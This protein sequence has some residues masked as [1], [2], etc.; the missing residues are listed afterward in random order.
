[1][2]M[3]HHYRELIAWRK[4]IAMVSDAYRL[5]QGFA[6]L[7]R[8]DEFLNQTAELGRTINGLIASPSA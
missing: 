2:S 6:E 8:A 4:A 1:M 7:D 3:A 5:P